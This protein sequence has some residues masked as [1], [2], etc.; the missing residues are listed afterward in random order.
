MSDSFLA[1]T[2]VRAND[3]AIRASFQLRAVT[4]LHAKQPG[5]VMR[6]DL[7]ATWSSHHAVAIAHSSSREWPS[8]RPCK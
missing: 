7:F 4:E 8:R 5:A 2:V 1:A 3:E 6:A